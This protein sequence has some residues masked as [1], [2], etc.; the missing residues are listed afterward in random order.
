MERNYKG[1]C[2]CGAVRY[3]IVGQPA[4][5]WACHCMI[6]QKQSGSAFAMA[7]VFQDFKVEV[8]GAQP[9]HFVRKGLNRSARC[10]FCAR[11]GTRLY[12]RW[13]N[14]QGDL[15]F[16]NLKPG[17]LDDTSWLK[18]AGLNTR[19]RGSSSLRM[20]SFSGSNLRRR[21]NGLGTMDPRSRYIGESRHSNHDDFFGCRVLADFVAEVG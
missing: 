9:D 15:P 8:A 11:C 1:G 10:Y 5:I 12:H 13:F 19:N 17:T 4:F 2:Q 14:D 20:I 18:P 21:Q 6:C 16:L 7:V 3:E